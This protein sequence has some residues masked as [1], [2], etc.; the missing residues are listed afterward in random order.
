M[1]IFADK[2]L[3]LSEEKLYGENIIYTHNSPYQRIALTRNNKDFRLYLNNNLQFSS[4]DEYRYHEA[5]IHPA[6][7][8]APVISNVLVLGGGDGFAVREILKYKEVKNV[9]LVDL[10]AEMTRF[11][12]ENKTMRDLNHNA[13]NNSKV[14][15]INQDAYLWVKNAKSKFDVI[16]IDFPIRLIIVLEN[17]ILS[18]FIKS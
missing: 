16:I 8:M 7:S 14:S 18:N 3:A 9:T 2:I 10:D 17:Y 4:A 15:I 13:L 1:F 5:L 11:F 6:M 12:R